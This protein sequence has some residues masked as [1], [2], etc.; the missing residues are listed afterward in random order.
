MSKEDDFEK[1]KTASNN[2]QTFTAIELGRKYVSKFINHA[3]AWLFYGRALVEACRYKEAL[4]SYL[5]GIKCC[6]ENRKGY[7]YSQLGHMYS[8]KGDFEEAKKWYVKASEILKPEDEAQIW[9]TE[10]LFKQGKFKEAEKELRKIVENNNELLDEACHLLGLVLS[11]QENYWEA[12]KWYKKAIEVNSSLEK[13]K[14]AIQDIK[15]VLK[16]QMKLSN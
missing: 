10:I 3:P 6:E 12:I 1:L 2:G 13:A 14:E 16:L 7:F 15:N 4:E 5:A 8:L 9:K 11:A